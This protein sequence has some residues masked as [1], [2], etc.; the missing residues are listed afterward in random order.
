MEFYGLGGGVKHNP[1][2]SKIASCVRDVLY[3]FPDGLPTVSTDW[4]DTLFLDIPI[5]LT[6]SLQFKLR[7]SVHG[8]RKD[9]MG[10]TM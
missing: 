7:N 2:P 5:A 4:G 10:I 3:G 1:V 9:Y 6:C 8:L